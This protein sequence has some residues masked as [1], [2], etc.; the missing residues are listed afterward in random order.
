MV[1]HAHLPARGSRLQL[2]CH[3]SDGATWVLLICAA[4]AHTDA[5]NDSS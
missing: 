5:T 1:L 4:P 3:P 2:C